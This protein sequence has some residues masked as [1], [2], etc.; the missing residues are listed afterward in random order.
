MNID[1]LIVAKPKEHIQQSC[2][3]S[4]FLDIGL[5][6]NSDTF[7]QEKKNNVFFNYLYSKYYC[8]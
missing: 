1:H 3:L 5:Y 7:L 8:F 4:K 2:S 6:Q